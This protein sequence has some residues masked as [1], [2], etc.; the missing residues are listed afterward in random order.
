M[1]F[2]VF[3]DNGGGHHWAIIAASGRTLVQSGS[4]AS[5][6]DAKQAARVVHGGAASASFEQPAGVAR[7]DLAVRGDTPPV[8]DEMRTPNAGKTKAAASAARR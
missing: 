2:L 7:I 1:K 3:E 6:E 8:R 4:F 5:Y